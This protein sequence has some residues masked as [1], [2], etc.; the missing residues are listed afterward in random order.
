MKVLHVTFTYA[1]DPAGGTEVYVDGLSH[2]LIRDGVEC[3]VAAP[4]PRD[5]RYAID[6]LA[7]RRFGCAPGE[8]SL[9]VLY[10]SGDPAASTAFDRVLADERPDVVHQHALSPACSTDLLRRAKRRGI[11]VVFTYHTPTVSCQ[12]GTLLRWGH[13]P[14]SGILDETRCTPCVLDDLGLNPLVR[15][16][17]GAIPSAVGQQLGRRGMEGGVWTALRLRS[18]METRLRETR[19]LFDRVDRFVS[20]T[21]WVTQVLAANGVS[22]SRIV[23]SPHGVS[24]PARPQAVQA[25][26][27]SDRKNPLRVAHLGRVDPTKGTAVLIRA[28]VSRPRLPLQLDIYGVQQSDEAAGH[29]K[30]LRQLA[31]DD[32]RIRFLPAVPHHAVIDTLGLYDVVAVPSQW[33]ETGPLV[34]L[35]AFAAGV[36]VLGS[37]LGGIADKIQHDVNGLLVPT[38]HVESAWASVIERCVRDAALLP[39]L[40][41]G[42]E[43]PRSMASVARDMIQVYRDVLALHRRP[44]SVGV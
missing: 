27:T 26:V 41:E 28:V 6:G 5:D 12:R 11:P 36:P 19:E 14:C 1:P 3:V 24:I 25:D 29:A 38:Y 33:V 32:P 16:I 9:D 13:E 39:R 34:V 43:R 30:L 15:G 10:G 21:P 40:R 4:G 18:L 35:E 23:F 37:E 44:A 8:Q 2:A 31:G 42:V 17:V 7:V 22:P 20:L